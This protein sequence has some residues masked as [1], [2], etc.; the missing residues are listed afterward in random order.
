MYKILALIK[1]A[2]RLQIRKEFKDLYAKK[3]EE[4]QRQLVVSQRKNE[5]AALKHFQDDFGR[6]DTPSPV[7]D[8]ELLN[9][10]FG[11]S[12]TQKDGLLKPNPKPKPKPTVFSQDREPLIVPTDSSISSTQPSPDSVIIK[13]VPRK[14]KCG[15]LVHNERTTVFDDAVKLFQKYKKALHSQQKLK[16]ADKVVYGKIEG[17]YPL[18][19]GDKGYHRPHPQDSGYRH[20]SLQ[21][22]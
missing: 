8:T 18:R 9:R 1:H 3:R 19:M 11:S 12:G 13:C 14:N 2:K 16:R 7:S 15:S 22:S 6:V 21:N 20:C 5:L 4:E 17:K 10:A